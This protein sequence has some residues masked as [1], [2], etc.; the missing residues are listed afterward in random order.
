MRPFQISL[1]FILPLAVVLGGFALV[2]LPL[3]DELTQ[4]WFLR[5][6]DTRSELLA[7]S[8]NAPLLDLVTLQDADGVHQYHGICNA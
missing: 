5:D 4:R 1:R 3:V 7:S 6:L 2:M 8:L